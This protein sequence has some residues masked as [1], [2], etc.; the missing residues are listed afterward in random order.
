MF[1]GSLTCASQRPSLRAW[2]A[3]IAFLAL[4]SLPALSWPRPQRRSPP[5]SQP[6]TAARPPMAVRTIA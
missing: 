6:L 2:V 4:F 3:L 5:A 1:F